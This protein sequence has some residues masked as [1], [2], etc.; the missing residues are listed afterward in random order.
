MK[1][2]TLI[3]IFA[4]I[5]LVPA[6]A[7]SQ[8]T[9]NNIFTCNKNGQ[10]TASAGS[11]TV[12]GGPYVPV[13]DY[14]VELNTGLLVYKE[15]VL[16]EIVTSQRKAGIAQVINQNLTKFNTGN[17]GGS[18]AQQEQGREEVE[19]RDNTRLRYLQNDSLSTLAAPLQGPVK[20]AIALGYKNERDPR[21]AFAC[22]YADNGGN[23][24]AVY[25]GIPVGDYWTGFDAVSTDPG[26]VVFEAAGLAD[27]A[28]AY[29]EQ[30]EIY[31]NRVRIENGR[32]VY[33]VAHYDEYGFRVTDTP[34]TFVNALTEQ[35]LTSPLRQAEQA[36]DINEMLDGLY[37]GIGNQVLTSGT[38]ATTGTGGVNT[39]G[40]AGGLSTITQALGG[41]LSYL[42]QVVQGSANE[43]TGQTGSAT[44]GA[45]QAA[46]ATE[47]QYNGVISS[48]ANLFTQTISTLRAKEQQ[49]FTTIANSVCQS[50]S[51]ASS[52]CT[53]QSGGTLNITTSTG[54]SQKVIEASIRSLA[55]ATVTNLNSSNQIIT[56]LQ[57]LAAGLAANSTQVAQAAALTA[58]AA[59]NPHTSSDVNA[60]Q[61]NQ[62]SLT[63]L[64]SNLI[65]NTSTQ[66]SESAG[67]WCNV[68]D[69]SVRNAWSSC[70]GGNSTAC[71]TP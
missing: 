26:C 29:Q 23:L 39:G 35:A 15:C 11:T 24:A 36:D 41:A 68:N 60:A 37:L 42:S 22:E 71:P 4:L 57:A 65:T 6:A 46:L 18:F 44:T 61:S 31:K 16:R 30:Y 5:G 62:Q 69:E 7:F 66:W 51:I 9:V 12:L 63:T 34:A 54:F 59:I 8:Q 2:T 1:K 45:I 47:R 20:Q 53:S 38:S 40:S 27:D 3:I 14:A 19:I 48:S 64:M 56:K 67:A 17:A 25:N 33:D 21:I 58:L 32:G 50:G 10:V 70:W 28:I 49:C 55:N 52:T 13:A 43:Y